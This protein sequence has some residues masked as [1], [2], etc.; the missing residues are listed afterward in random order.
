MKRRTLLLLFFAI[1]IQY[2]FSQGNV[3]VVDKIVLVDTINI[4]KP[5]CI[6][7]KKQ[8]SFLMDKNVFE[9][10]QGNEQF[11]F[12]RNDVYLYAEELPMGINFNSINDSNG[13]MKIFFSNN[14]CNSKIQILAKDKHQLEFE[15]IYE[16]EKEPD[17]YLLFLINGDFYDE[18]Y[19]GIDGPRPLNLNNKSF[20]YYKLLIP[21][22]LIKNEN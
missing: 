5:V 1:F 18:N 21:I 14:S 20:S 7:T 17:L 3:D 6:L 16:Y 13:F 4:K 10:Y 8:H 12:S 9:R 11:L 2:I 15:Y 22:C 19:T